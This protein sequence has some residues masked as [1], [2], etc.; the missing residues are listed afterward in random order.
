MIDYDYIF[1]YTYLLL[2]L[3]LAAQQNNSTKTYIA[4]INLIYD[5]IRKI[6]HNYELNKQVRDDF[7]FRQL[8][9]DIKSEKRELINVKVDINEILSTLISSDMLEKVSLESARIRIDSYSECLDQ[10]AFEILGYQAGISQ[11]RQTEISEIINLNMVL[12]QR[13][14]DEIVAQLIDVDNRMNNVLKNKN[15]TMNIF[16]EMVVITNLTRA[17]NDSLVLKKR[18]MDVHA[19][20]SERITLEDK[21]LDILQDNNV[22]LNIL[23][24]DWLVQFVRTY[25]EFIRKFLGN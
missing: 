21:Q 1:H 10:I 15:A 3:L 12:F 14:T 7:K 17:V 13:G 22:Q 2:L 23:T 24:I 4:K 18:L 20:E 11:F 19:S 9:T 16:N 6:Y 5:Q 8:I 25:Q